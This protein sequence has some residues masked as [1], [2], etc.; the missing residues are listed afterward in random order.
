[1]LRIFSRCTCTIDVDMCST[2]RPYRLSEVRPQERAQRRTVQQIVDPVPLPTL[3]NPAPQ[4]VGQLLNL[5][6]PWFARRSWR[7]SW[8]KC[9]R[10]YLGPCCSCLRSRTSTF[11]FLVVEREFLVF[12]VFFPDRVQQH[13]LHLQLVFMVLQMGLVKGFFALIPKFKKV[14]SWARTRGRNCS[15]S[16]AHPRRQL[17]W[18]LWRW[19]SF[20]P[21]SSSSLTR[22]VTWNAGTHTMR[23]G[24]RRM[25]RGCTASSLTRGFVLNNLRLGPTRL[26]E[27][28]MVQGD[29]FR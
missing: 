8:W 1:M 4:L 18:T 17:M 3:E 7:N 13:L 5:D 2:I 23:R 10:S 21:S 19:W 28:T 24:S 26:Q 12:K 25:S 6:E 16:R 14:R 9:R 29:G 15:P 11:Q 22:L 20:W 27:T